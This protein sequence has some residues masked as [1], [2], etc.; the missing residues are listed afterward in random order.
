MDEYRMTLF[1][2]LLLATGSC[3][4]ILSQEVGREKVGEKGNE[5]VLKK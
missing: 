5:G 1:L 4:R 3:A 2:V